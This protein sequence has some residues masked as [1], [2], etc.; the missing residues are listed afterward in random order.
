MSIPAL[1]ESMNIRSVTLRNRLWV[2]PMCEYSVED[3]DGVPTD[4]H[5]V[6]LGSF[7]TGGAGLV[8][9]EATAVSPI[10]RISPQDTGIYTDEQRDAWGR[11][12]AFLHAQGAATGVQL[13]HAGRKASTFPPF[14]EGKGTVP[15]SDGGW[16]TVAPSAVAYDAYS[17]PSPLSV[18][19][20]EQVV[21]DFVAAARRAMAAG[22]DLLEI[23][24]AHG[25]LIHQF[26]SP[27]SNQ[28]EDAYG[29]TLHNRAR[30]LLDVVRA[31]RAEVGETVPLFVRL[32]ATDWADGGLD[33][34]Q[35]ATVAEW[36]SQAGADV[37][38]ISTGGLIAGVSIP[39]GPAYQVP[40]ADF[41]KHKSSVP[42][43][44]VGLITTAAQANEIVA[45]G[46]ADA[47]MLARELLRDPHF[48]L[49]AA[50]ELGYD[51]PYWPKQYLRAKLPV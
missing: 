30:L 6:H 16:Q 39:F 45:S 50:R 13:A 2:S 21:A 23:H 32:S 40:F 25:Y 28:R 4:W 22:F 44:S 47:V 20:I 38:D 48:P 24:G 10:G 11:I 15:A 27:L 42:V 5:L 7:A 35:I 33:Q 26:L 19:D 18:A 3:R 8:M 34:E 9:T 17:V 37:F 43:S 29:G 1:F 51:L 36:A 14:D 31:V 12:V 46:Q 41:V 49:R